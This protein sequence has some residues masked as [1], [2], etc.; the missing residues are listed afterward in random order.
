MIQFQSVSKSFGPIKVLKNLNL[1]INQ[2]EIIGLLGPNGAGKTTTLRLITGILPPS[3]GQVFINNQDISQSSEDFKKS[4]GYLP[5]NNPLYPDLT[6][7]EY[8]KFTASLKNLSDQQLPN[9]YAQALKSADLPKVTHRL[10]GELSK[11]F[12]QRVGLAQAI[13]GE[14]EILILDEPTEGL[15][16]NQRTQIHD[17]IKS[18]GKNRT[19][20]ISSHVLPEITKIAN[21]I[22][23][24]HQGQIVA[25]GTPQS[26]TASQKGQVTITAELAGKNLQAQL[27][28][29]PGLTHLADKKFKTHNQFQLQFQTDKTKDDP[30]LLVS[31]LAAQQKWQLFELSQK[32]ESLEDVFAQLTLNNP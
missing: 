9:L 26:L 10:I 2:G 31:Q 3:S 1:T 18:L 4:I 28:K 23:I 17:L 15:D 32:T 27:K 5:E 24:I 20:V 29:L 16:P 22:I 19:V 25:D 11:G 21:R 7:A 14:P 12:R 13:I 30:R 6:V 8:L